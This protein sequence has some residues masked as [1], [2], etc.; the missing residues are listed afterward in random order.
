LI[1][2]T[3][4]PAAADLSAATRALLVRAGQAALDAEGQ[5]NLEVSVTVVSDEAMRVIHRDYLDDDSPTDVVT[6]PLRE[7]GDPDALLGEVIVGVDRASAEATARGIPFAEELA[8]YVVH[9]C[10]HLCGYDDKTPALRRKMYARQED[11]LA[12]V[13]AGIAEAAGP[14]PRMKRPTGAPSPAT[15][16]SRPAPPP[17]AKRRAAKKRGRGA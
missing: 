14:R 2:L 8:R 13:L 10:L 5:G 15:A 9:G 7:E 17:K 6:F 12:G 11:V 4:D 16:K 3:D 1:A